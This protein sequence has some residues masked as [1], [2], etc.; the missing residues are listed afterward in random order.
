MWLFRLS[1]AYQIRIIKVG[2]TYKSL[3]SKQTP[4]E[5]GGG[6]MGRENRAPRV[7]LIYTQVWRT[8]SFDATKK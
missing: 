7:L 4:K 2:K 3:F 8:T 5:K 6:R 1:Q